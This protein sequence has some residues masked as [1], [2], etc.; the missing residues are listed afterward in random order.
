MVD[1]IKRDKND[2]YNMPILGFLFKNPVFLLL[3]KVAISVLFAYAIV[4]GFYNDTKE[5]L[6][7][8][9]LFWGLFWPFF[10]VITLSSFGRLFCG[11]CPHGFIGKYITKYGLNKKIPKYLQNPFIG[12]LILIIGWWAVYYAYP[13]L[14][15]TPYATAFLFTLLTVFA[16]VFFYLYEKM[17]YCKYICPI[18]I[19][20][21]AFSKVSFTWLSTYKSACSDCKTFECSKACSY[22]LKPFTFDKKNSLEDCTLCMDCSSACEA[23]SFKV[24]KPSFSLFNKIKINKAEI[25]GYILITASISITMGF[26]H[27]LGRT[28][29]VDEFIWSKT[30]FYFQDILDFKGADAVGIFA[31]LYAML[32]TI[33]S[34]VFGM[35][36]GSKI[37][38]VS[39]EKTFYTLGYAFA[40]LFIIGGL[41]HMGEF[42]FYHYASDIANAF[43]QAFTI[44]VAYM[45]PLA[46]RKDKWVHVFSIFN[47]IAVIWALLIM[48]GRLKLIDSSKIRKVIAFPFISALIVFYLGLNLYKGYVFKEYGVKKTAHSHSAK[49]ITKKDSHNGH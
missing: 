34:A 1:F 33:M 11:I 39:Y 44:D 17:S 42:F 3:F 37:L 38:K 10:M 26:H 41:S 45:E 5:N 15:K 24:K 32:F 21:R 43:I 22:D 28:A 7:T 30:A 23:V 20:T 31:F 49:S 12:L 18:G 16:F 6:F 9:G 27:A 29:I 8:K 40:P 35:F 13:S 14:F 4:Y 36:I 19:L 2:M 47:H 46:T 25:W 48:I